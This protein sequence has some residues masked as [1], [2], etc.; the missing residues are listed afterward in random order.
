MVGTGNRRFFSLR[1][2]FVL[3][4]FLTFDLILFFAC[5]TSF[6]ADRSDRLRE[7]V[8]LNRVA[9]NVTCSNLDARDFIRKLFAQ[10]ESEGKPL[11]NVVTMNL[12]ATAISFLD[13]FRG[14]YA[15]RNLPRA[16]ANGAEDEKKAQS[17][18]Y[19]QADMPR[20]HCYCFSRGETLAEMTQKALERVNNVLGCTPDV[21]VWDV[22]N[23]APKKQMFCL[24][25]D[26]PLAC[27]T[28]TGAKTQG[29]SGA[30][31]SAMKSAG[32]KRKADGPNSASV[33]AESSGGSAVAQSAITSKRR[34]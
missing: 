31:D 5:W 11:F 10:L 12:P 9:D 13:V 7:N 34:K 15:K 4:A 2:F 6:R 33:T 16:G 3:L 22:R 8:A 20:I 14:L 26:L 28:A 30:D 32:V 24:S 29:A 21:Q 27:G 1:H 25:F 18:V 17:R 19:T 23:V